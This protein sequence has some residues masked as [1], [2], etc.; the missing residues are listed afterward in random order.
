MHGKWSVALIFALVAA[1]PAAADDTVVVHVDEEEPGVH[2]AYTY[3][4]S[5]GRHGGVFH[6]GADGFSCT[7][8][9]EM[10]DYRCVSLP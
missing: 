10:Y 3:D 9:G 7:G 6:I 5:D 1:A 2:A 4:G 8:G